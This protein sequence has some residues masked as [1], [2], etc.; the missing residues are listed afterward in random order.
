MNPTGRGKLELGVALARIVAGLQWGR[1]L[2]EQY[3]SVAHTNL[4]EVF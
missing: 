3:S 2:S 4:Q 1:V